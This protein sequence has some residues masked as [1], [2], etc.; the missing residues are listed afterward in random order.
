MKRTASIKCLT[1]CVLY[2]LSKKQLDVVL[3]HHPQMTA[4]IR[5]VA[6]QRLRQQEQ[7]KK[8]AIKEEASTVSMESPLRFGNSAILEDQETEDQTEDI[9]SDENLSEGDP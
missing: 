7:E 3:L 1:P 4:A 5:A 8:A 6:E 9:S 2:S